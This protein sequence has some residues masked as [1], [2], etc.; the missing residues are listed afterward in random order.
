ML[1]VP[2]L[3]LDKELIIL[4]GTPTFSIELVHKKLA[5]WWSWKY[6]EY[7]HNYLGYYGYLINNRRMFNVG[8][9]NLVV[10]PY[11]QESVRA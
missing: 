9:D 11:I 4:L 7:D 2:I 3:V 8:I 5:K 1:K 10:K 6:F